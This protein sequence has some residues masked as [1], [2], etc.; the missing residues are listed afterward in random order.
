MYIYKKYKKKIKY[1]T[2]H[3]LGSG[4]GF[5]AS[6]NLISGISKVPL[7]F[8]VT[9]NKI[10]DRIFKKNLQIKNGKLILNDKPGI[11]INLNF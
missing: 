6:A 7:E 4:P 10:R 5:F 9:E 3:Y 8:D 2:P 11:G 1:L